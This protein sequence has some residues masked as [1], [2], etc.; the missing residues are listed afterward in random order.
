VVLKAWV[1]QSAGA[2]LAA[3][4][5]GLTDVVG[6]VLAGPQQRPA[7]VARSGTLQTDL[8]RLAPIAARI[9]EYVSVLHIGKDDRSA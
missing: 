6:A 2:A 8:Q 4:Q 7:V 3:P 1:Q 5:A 9:G